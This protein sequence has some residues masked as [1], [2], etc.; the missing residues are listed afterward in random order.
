MDEQ[1]LRIRLGMQ[2]L[3]RADGHMDLIQ[4]LE[5]QAHRHDDDY[6]RQILLDCYEELE[7][8]LKTLVH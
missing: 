5:D 4:A 2:L 1:E 6:T 7:L 8:A 3:Y